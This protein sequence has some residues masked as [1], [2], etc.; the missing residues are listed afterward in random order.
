MSPWVRR[1]IACLALLA[2]PALLAD[3]P[4]EKPDPEAERMM[5][6]AHV[7][8]SGWGGDFPGFRAEAAATLDGDHAS[9][10]VTVQA[11][12]SVAWE[13]PSGPAAEWAV[14]QLESVAMH[15][16]AGVRDE[17]DVSFADD[18]TDHPLGRLIRFHGGSTHSLYR[19]KDDVITEVHRRMDEVRFTITVTDVTRTAEGK[20]LPRHFNVSY[21]DAQTGDLKSNDDFQDDWARVGA[22]D[23]P[24]RRLMVRTAKD[25]RQVAEL[26]LTN[27]AL[28]EPAAGK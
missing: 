3:E 23:L 27:H 6:E 13:G 17:Y 9:G 2:A 28:L 11:D 18:V 12:G 21:W 15:R 25:Q 8:R 4:A 7:A 10:G 1:A 24:A 22:F 19:I 5:R 16:S 26:V 20:T 14:G